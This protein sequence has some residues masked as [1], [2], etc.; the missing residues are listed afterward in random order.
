MVKIWNIQEHEDGAKKRVSLVA[1][2]D[3]GLVSGMCDYRGVLT[4]PCPF[5]P[6]R[7]L[8]DCLVSGRSF[9]ACR[10]R[11]K[12]QIT[13]LGRRRELWCAQGV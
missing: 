9:N 12:S 3:L 1:G 6:G 8:L 13:N 10:R 5:H 2:R 7:G 11:L 4:E